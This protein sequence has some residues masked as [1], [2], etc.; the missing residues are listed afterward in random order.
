MAC[1]RPWNYFMMSRE[2]KARVDKAWAACKAAEADAKARAV[3]ATGTR[4]G[5]AWLDAGMDVVGALAAGA[6]AYQGG[7]PRD[8]STW[9]PVAGAIGGA[10]NE[11]GTAPA[12]VPYQPPSD[13]GPSL[14]TDPIGWATANPVPAIAGLAIVTKLAKL[15]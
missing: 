12:P 10:L 11:D 8:P 6:G 15:W 4:A 7:D 2:G 5:D 9:A 13:V 3:E 1:N 14:T